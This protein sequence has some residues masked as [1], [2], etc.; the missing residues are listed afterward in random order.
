MDAFGRMLLY[1]GIFLFFSH[2]CRTHWTKSERGMFLLLGCYLL[3]KLLPN[4]HGWLL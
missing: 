4:E 3:P 2:L 1:P